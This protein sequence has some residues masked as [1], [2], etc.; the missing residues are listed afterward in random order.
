MLNASQLWDLIYFAKVK[1]VM[2]NII[3]LV[4]A[5][6]FVWIVIDLLYCILTEVC[7]LLQKKKGR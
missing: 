2:L 5:A 1:A 3:Q 7:L 4:I 6:L